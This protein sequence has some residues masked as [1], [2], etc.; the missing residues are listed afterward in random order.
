LYKKLNLDEFVEFILFLFIFCDLNFV[1]YFLKSLSIKYYK[2]FKTS[3]K[4]CYKLFKWWK[5]LLI[6]LKESYFNLKKSFLNLIELYKLYRKKLEKSFKSNLE[7]KILKLLSSKI[8]LITW[9]IIFLTKVLNNSKVLEWKEFIL[10][11]IMKQEISESE[12]MK[13][14]FDIR[15][16]LH[17]KN[18]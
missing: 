14:G 9:E 10:L 15:K 16:K 11:G 13:W 4:D 2:V 3:T 1:S 5:I 6:P 8:N 17:L 7:E 18:F 12:N